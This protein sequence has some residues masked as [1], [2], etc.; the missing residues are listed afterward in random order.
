M[1]PDARPFDQ[2]RL[3]KPPDPG[4][5]TVLASFRL[6]PEY[7]GILEYFA[8]FTDEQAKD[9]SAIQTKGLTWSLRLNQQPFA[10]YV[11][12]DH[13]ANPWG[14]GGFPI[15]L[16]LEEGSSVD[17]VVRGESPKQPKIG[18]VGGRLVGRYWY[19]RAFGDVARTGMGRS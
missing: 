11:G 6:P 15:R 17:L 14:I 7:C 12:L 19:N 18:L 2:S 5:L 1:P 10:P 4:R 8:Q 16:K 3:E 13:I 9:P